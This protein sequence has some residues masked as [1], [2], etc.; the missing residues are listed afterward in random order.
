[1]VETALDEA[2]NDPYPT[3]AVGLAGQ[4][5]ACRTHDAV[6]RLSR[7]TAP[8]LVL[9]GADDILS[10]VSYAQELVERTPRARLQ[11][12]ELCGHIPYLEEP[13]A[14]LAALLAFLAD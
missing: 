14:V 8:T 11:V 4:V 3:T 7:I 1:M 6:V 2:A 9:V 5:A 12:I 13:G 10:P